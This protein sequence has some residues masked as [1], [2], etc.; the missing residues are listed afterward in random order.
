MSLRALRTPLTMA[1]L[2]LLREEPRHPYALQAQL[3]Y[4]HVGEVV[5][6]RGGSVYDAVRRLQS[7]GLVSEQ[8]TN[9]AGARPERTVYA[10]TEQGEE[11]LEVEY[12]QR[13]RQAELAW[14]HEVVADLTDGTLP[15]IE[16][17]LVRTS[18][19]RE[20]AVNV[21]YRPGDATSPIEK[22]KK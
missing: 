3:R 21:R 18:S 22:V 4:R 15:W 8:E 9:R 10:T 20:S 13:L 17:G 2:S 11:L 14:L 16:K 19:Q 12:A 5:K 6:L 1:I 7:A